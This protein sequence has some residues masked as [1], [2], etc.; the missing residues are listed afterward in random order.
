MKFILPI[1]AVFLTSTITALAQVTSPQLTKACMGLDNGTR[2]KCSCMAGKFKQALDENE[3]TYAL[4]MLTLNAKLLE[5]L[6]GN[7]EDEM[8]TAVKAKIIPLM[9]DCLL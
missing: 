1:L 7:F 3:K 9:M 4:A 8:A 6:K 5:P 2:E